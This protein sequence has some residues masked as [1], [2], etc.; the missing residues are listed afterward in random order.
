MLGDSR[1]F[2]LFLFFFS[3]FDARWL[4][5]R[6]CVNMIEELIMKLIMIELT[7]TLN[8]KSGEC[9]PVTQLHCKSA[10][11]EIKLV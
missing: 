11:H 4:N 8:L 3:N 2:F 1:K 5:A 9:I 10:S 7:R 6:P